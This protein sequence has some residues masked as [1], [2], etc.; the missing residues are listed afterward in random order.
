MTCPH[1]VGAEELFGARQAR[2]D[3]KRYRA[4]GPLKTA[5]MLIDALRA[6]G[7]EDKRLLDIGGGA[8]VL[9][10]ELLK[11]GMAG[12][13]GV[14]GSSA[15]IEAARDESARRGFDDRVTYRHGDFL[16]VAQTLEQADVVTLDRV[17]CCYPDVDALVARSTDLADELYGVVYPRKTLGA[18]VAIRLANFFL[19]VKRNPFRAFVH[20]PRHVDAMVREAGFEERYRAT[21]L[22]WHVVVYQR[23]RTLR[24]ATP[25]ASV[26]EAA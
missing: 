23:V 18:R 13:V 16:D 4:K 17:L 3:L 2:A 6:L 25:A 5:Q 1:C 15:Y 22:V 21:T 10:H 14:D 8:G 7:V 9:Q 12:A 26:A 11:A 20:D 24:M 19:K